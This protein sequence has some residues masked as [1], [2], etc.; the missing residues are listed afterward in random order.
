[1][2]LLHAWLLLCDVACT[3]ESTP[4]TRGSIQEPIEAYVVVHSTAVFL[5]ALFL[6]PE[7]SIQ[8]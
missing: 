8:C 4:R 7:V 3:D 1:M 2:S 5:C 6:G